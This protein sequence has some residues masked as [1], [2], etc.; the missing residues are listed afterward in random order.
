[1]CW[2]VSYLAPFFSAA[3]CSLRIVQDTCV[4][5]V[6]TDTCVP[7]V[8]TDTC[9]PVVSTD[10][11]VPVVATDTCVPVVATTTSFGLMLPAVTRCRISLG[12]TELCLA[13]LSLKCSTLNEVT[14]PKAPVHRRIQILGVLLNICIWDSRSRKREALGHTGLWRPSKGLC[15]LL[16]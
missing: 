11:C 8:A 9:V 14:K 2:G 12:N 3:T 4:P 6:A 16:H 1:M 5:V 13:S 15:V 7:V 10:T